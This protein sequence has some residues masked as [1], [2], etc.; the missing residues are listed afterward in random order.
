MLMVLLS[1]FL[2]YYILSSFCIQALPV[3]VLLHVED[4]H[5]Q[6]GQ[7][8]VMGASGRT[9]SIRGLQQAAFLRQRHQN[10]YEFRIHRP[11][12]C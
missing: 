7:N 5:T 8:D 9:V 6:H 12:H 1:Y 11:Y 3:E 2:R 10:I 4:D